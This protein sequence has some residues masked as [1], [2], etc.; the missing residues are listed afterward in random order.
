M[1]APSKRTGKYKITRDRRI[2]KAKWS[3]LSA[4]EKLLLSPN[5]FTEMP[6][7][8]GQGIHRLSIS[9]ACS[10]HQNEVLCELC[11]L[12]ASKGA[13]IPSHDVREKLRKK[14]KTRT[15]FAS[16]SSP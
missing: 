12:F 2:K 8:V 15:R 6:L 11:P 4:E 14:P 5:A 13:P 7:Y 3:F 9:F 1:N 16:L 10:F